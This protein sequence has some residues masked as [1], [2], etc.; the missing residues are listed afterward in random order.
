MATPKHGFIQPV[1]GD[2]IGATLLGI[3][4]T[5]QKIEDAILGSVLYYNVKH[6]GAVGDGVA[7]DSPAIQTLVNQL[8][9]TGTRAGTIYFPRGK[10]RIVTPINSYGNTHINYLANTAADE[11]YSQM[12]GPMVSVR[13]LGEGQE[14]TYL[15]ADNS[16]G[17]F[18][19]YS[20]TPDDYFTI[21]CEHIRFVGKDKTGTCAL[22]DNDETKPLRIYFKN[23]AFNNFDVGYKYD[24][25]SGTGNINGFAHFVDCQFSGNNNGIYIGSDNIL[26]EHCFV[27][28]N[29]GHGMIIGQ[30]HNCEIIGGKL[31]YNG[32]SITTQKEQLFITAGTYAVTFDTVYFEPSFG[33]EGYEGEDANKDRYLMRFDR[34]TQATVSRSIKFQNCWF[35]C[36]YAGLMWTDNL[37]IF[38]LVID[39]GVLKM[40]R[41]TANKEIFNFSMDTTLRDLYIANLQMDGIYD[42]TGTNLI[43]DWIWTTLT[44]NT[45]GINVSS[46]IVAIESRTNGGRIVQITGCVGSTGTR[47]FGISYAS[48][49]TGT[50]VYRID[51]HKTNLGTNTDVVN[52]PVIVTPENNADPIIASVAHVDNNSFDIYLKKKSDNSAIDANF[53]FMAMV[54]AA[55]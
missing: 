4:N 42:S 27:I 20:A 10:Y 3:G 48:S 22:I 31:E 25:Y 15:I 34:S 32:K 7:D 43:T 13:F 35:N 47:L 37:N 49:R 53:S 40:A 2:K 44:I 21:N 46:P 8:M 28:H 39:G 19:P 5:M 9:T 29:E 1:T 12:G 33:L 30:T 51:L 26:L 14:S 36:L 16:T 38:G 18:H 23:C 41:T 52:M 50:G 45:Y 6:Y 17:I 55:Q 24:R 11:L 54:S